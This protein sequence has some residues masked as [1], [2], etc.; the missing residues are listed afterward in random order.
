MDQIVYNNS[1]KIPDQFAST[2]H[3]R[4]YQFPSGR[5]I[6]LLPHLNLTIRID[7]GYSQSIGK[8][9]DGEQAVRCAIHQYLT[10]SVAYE[11]L[12]WVDYETHHL[13]LLRVY[14]LKCSIP[15]VFAL[16]IP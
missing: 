14:V 1:A 8:D 5:Q 9:G 7:D 12:R 10:P 2:G 15:P 16:Q 4:N 11:R 3:G 13:Y 6:F